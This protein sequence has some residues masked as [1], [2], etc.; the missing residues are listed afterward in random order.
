VKTPLLLLVALVLFAAGCG[1]T[2]SLD[3]V[4]KAADVSAQQTSE[5]MT[6]T[7]TVTS[8]IQTVTMK[9]AGD[10]QNDPNL[11]QM[12]LAVTGGPQAISIREVLQGTTVYMTSDL[13]NGQLPGGKSWLKLD[14]QKTMKSL[15]VD[16]A[17]LSS[18][19]PTDALARLKTSGTVTKLG[20]QTIGGVA[21]THYSAILD[22]G[23]VA[24]LTRALGMSISYGPVDAWIDAHGLVRRVHLTAVLDGS[25]AVP[26]A[27]M[28]MTMSLSNYGEHVAVTPPPDDETFDVTDLAT[29]FL[30]K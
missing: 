11:G 22:A 16:F 13:F 29:Q 9:G 21:T 24:K 7:A 30:K 2:V 28:E 8:G 5:H 26:Q 3:P 4:A 25:T 18:Q 6:M 10:F 12:T 27:A 14:L 23:R 17:T 20:P 15:G 1:D 19:S